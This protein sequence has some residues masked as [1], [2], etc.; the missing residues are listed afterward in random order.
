[1]EI[2]RLDANQ[3]AEYE[4][5]SAVAIGKFDG[6]HK[7]HRSLLKRLLLYKEKGL[8]TVVFSFEKSITAFLKGIGEDLIATEEEKYELL[9]QLGIDYLAIYPVNEESIRIEPEDFI[10]KVLVGQLKAKAIVAGEDCSFGRYGKGDGLLLE[11]KSVIYDYKFE[12]VEKVLEEYEGN[13]RE[14]SSTYIREEILKGN[15][16]HAAALLGRS[17]SVE[18][19]VIKGKQIGRTIDMPTANI[20][21][22]SKKLLPPNGV[23]LCRVFVKDKVYNGIS[24]IGVRPTIK[25]NAE[26]NIETYIFDFNENIYGDRIRIELLQFLRKEQKF[27]SLDKLKEQLVKDKELGLRLCHDKSI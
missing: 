5:H 12:C 26:K 23:Y 21:V 3:I 17:Y 4:G 19:T 15:M 9:E 25:D 8:K 7:G 22:P 10:E 20:N 2:I 13:V 1:V 18:G 16:E 27:E 11:N 14:I 6:I 24:N